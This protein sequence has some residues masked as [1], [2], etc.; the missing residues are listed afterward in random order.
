MS[1]FSSY[2]RSRKRVKVAHRMTPYDHAVRSIILDSTQKNSEQANILEGEAL[3]EDWSQRSSYMASQRHVHS[4]LEY[5]DKAGKDL[6]KDLRFAGFAVTGFSQKHGVYEQGFMA[7][8]GGVNTVMNTGDKYIEEG[9]EVYV[10]PVSS[11]KELRI[12]GVPRSKK[13]FAL[14]QDNSNLF[15]AAEEEKSTAYLK[16]FAVGTCIRG[17]RVG[18]PVDVVLHAN[19]SCINVS[20]SAT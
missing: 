2:G 19:S 10:L 16:K 5:F 15:K 9:K 6:L 1:S 8:I 14:V 18:Q 20:L 3:M 4:N 13:L 7:T 11:G 17:G 12:K